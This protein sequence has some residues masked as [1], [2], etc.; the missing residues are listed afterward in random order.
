MCTDLAR[1]VRHIEP[2]AEVTELDV[3]RTSVYERAKELGVNRV[4]ALVVN[5][6][7]IQQHDED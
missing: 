1:R 4:P 7:L 6:R 5:G 3:R 2:D